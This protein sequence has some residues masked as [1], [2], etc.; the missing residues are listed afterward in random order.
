MREASELPRRHGSCLSRA[1]ATSL[2]VRIFALQRRLPADQPFQDDDLPKELLSWVSG[3]S[4]EYCFCRYIRNHASLGA[5]LSFAP[6]V[7]VASHGGLPPHLHII[8]QH[9]GPRDAN[10]GHNH[11]AAP[12]SN[13][14]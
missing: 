5:Y 7:Q 6:D 4:Q 9:S 2:I 8:S 1:T 10:L 14:V 3:T 11:A 13:I 12:E